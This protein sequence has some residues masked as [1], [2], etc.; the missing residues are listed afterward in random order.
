M[1]QVIKSS[2]QGGKLLNLETIRRAVHRTAV[3]GERRSRSPLHNDL[4]YHVYIWYIEAV[5]CSHIPS[6][7]LRKMKWTLWIENLFT[8]SMC[9]DNTVSIRCTVV[10]VHCT[11]MMG[12]SYSFVPRHLYCLYIPSSHPL[13]PEEHH[14]FWLLLCCSWS[15]WRLS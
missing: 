15:L 2:A 14:Y 6:L 12:H 10:Y 8:F 11:L 13:Q 9:G 4:L 7:Q 1:R 3:F 5:D